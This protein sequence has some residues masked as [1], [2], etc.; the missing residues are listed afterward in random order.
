MIADIL[1]G[2]KLSLMI[3]VFLSIGIGVVIGIIVGALPGLTATMAVAI[4]LPFT[5]FIPAVV[6][7][8]F[9]VALT[10]GA[11]YGGSIPA[12]LMNT[13]GTGAAAATCFDGYPLAQQGKSRKALEMALYSSVIGDGVSDLITM[14]GIGILA[15]F[16]LLVS[17][18][19]YFSIILWSFTIIAVLTG[20]STIKGLI[21]AFAGF[22]FSTIGLSPITDVQRFTFGS[23]DLTGGFGIVPMI[24]GLFAIAEIMMQSERKVVRNGEK[25]Q[26]IIEIMKKKEAPLSFKE[27]K[28]SFITILRSTLVG[29]GIGNIPGIGQ[30]TSAF[31]CYGLAKGRSKNPEKF[32]KGALEGVAAAEA[33]NNAVNG[34]SLMPLLVF[35]IPGDVIAAILLG[36]FL[37][38]GLR[39]GP[40][41]FETQGP[42]VYSIL[43]AF[44]FANI[45]LL[46]L[47]FFATRYFAMISRFPKHLL[48]PLIGGLCFVGSYSVDNS[49]FDIFIALFFGVLGYIMNKFKFP[50]A[51]LLI[52]FIL[53]PMFETALGQSLIMSDGSFLIFLYRPI[54][55][56]F[57]LL[58]P[59]TLILILKH[60]KPKGS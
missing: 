48:F 30:V 28:E 18:P 17:A 1:L 35:G 12:I 43:W 51:P 2:L 57:V 37:I 24:I 3:K 27:L 5:F 4:F 21:S 23:L 46:I 19:E 22:F 33:G 9:L 38:Q 14:F 40:R 52:T 15:K 39:P 11:I 13:P 53:G 31:V 32:G 16:A 10:K 42:Q 41:L 26:S 49:I 55:L 58:T 29:T 56:A 47:G 6:G 7:I 54:S 44:I 8:P 20:E 25:E 45:V 60:F 36:A 59:I 34:P 50:I